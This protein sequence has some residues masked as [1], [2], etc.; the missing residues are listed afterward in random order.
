MAEFPWSFWHI[1]IVEFKALF[2][3][4]K[5]DFMGRLYPGKIFIFI[6][7]LRCHYIDSVCKRWDYSCVIGGFKFD[8][9]VKSG[10]FWNFFSF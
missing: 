5:K 7:Y 4:K 1:F 6:L 10:A 2:N 9:T 8:N 3:L